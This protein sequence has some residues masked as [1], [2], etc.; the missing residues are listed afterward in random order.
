MLVWEAF[1]A[2]NPIGCEVDMLAKVTA[3]ILKCYDNW[4]VFRPQES[5]L[6]DNRYNHMLQDED[7]MSAAVARKVGVFAA[8]LAKELKK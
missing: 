5:Q 7:A 8:G 2:A 3:A 6:H 1:Y 4:E